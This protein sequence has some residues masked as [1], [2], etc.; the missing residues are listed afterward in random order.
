MGPRL[1]FHQKR[2]I[3]PAE[4]VMM[5]AHGTLTDMRSQPVE[6]PGD[7]FSIPKESKRGSCRLEW[8]RAQSTDGKTRSLIWVHDYYVPRHHSHPD[9]VEAL[10]PFGP[11]LD[12]RL[13]AHLHP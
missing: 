3:L 1:P 5:P 11:L 4:S 7:G 9:C 13:K 10:S 8:A 6:L 2:H 12:A